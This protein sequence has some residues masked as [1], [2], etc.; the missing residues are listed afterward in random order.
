MAESTSRSLCA[1]AHRAVSGQRARTLR[2]VTLMLINTAAQGATALL[3]VPLLRAAGV[4][5]TSGTVGG[6]DRWISS[7]FRLAGLRPSLGTVLA[8]FV[9]VAW[10]QAILAQ[11]ELVETAR[12]EQRVVRDL[13]ASLYRALLAARWPF[14]T[15]R[16]G[17]DL[18][19]TVTRDT[20][21]AGAAVGYLARGAVQFA[22]ALVYAVLAVAVSPAAAGAALAGGLVLLLLLRP[23]LQAAHATGETLGEASSDTLALA[24]QHVDAIKLVKSYGAEF[25]AG[26]TFDAVAER[27]AASAVDATRAHARAHVAAA[28]GSA[29]LLGAVLYLAL[30][31]LRLDAAS[32]LLLAFLFWRLVPRLLDVQQSL[33]DALHELPGF[34]AV[35]RLLDASAAAREVPRAGD[36]AA[37]IPVRAEIAVER[38]SFAYDG[39]PVLNDASC[40]IPAGCITAFAGSSGAGKTTLVDLLLGLLTPTTGTI[41]VD[42]RALAPDWLASWR[43]TVAYVPQDA[44]LFHDSVLANL[45]WA[46]PSASMSDVWAALRAAAADGFVRALPSGLDTLVGDRGARLSGGERQRLALAR[47]LLRRPSVLVLDE[48]TSAV[49]AE[50]EAQMLDA[51]ERMRGAVTIVLVSHRDAPLARADRVYRIGDGAIT[52]QFSEA[53]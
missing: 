36:A 28:A 38:I 49:D 10:T 32:A 51:L 3:L 20:D 24:I 16:R 2:V 6:I 46:N 41:R 22:G 45:R 40:V 53:V 4:P 21:R 52:P 18:A 23:T 27:S 43:A 25:Q 33:R 35:Q 34:E 11:R 47:A 14:F 29:T 17:S 44:L 30:G 15:E 31:V 48:A 37:V 26:E 50:S 7:A 5:A 39:A 8:A 12:F 1:L 13:R 19:H 9:A 42:G